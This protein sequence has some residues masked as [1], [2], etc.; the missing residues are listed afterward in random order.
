M[1]GERPP[2]PPSPTVAAILWEASNVALVRTLGPRKARAFVDALV[3]EVRD[4]ETVSELSLMRRG[5]K[6]LVSADREVVTE[7]VRTFQQAVPALIR[8]I[9]R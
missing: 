9:P 8:A 2:P 6:S 1:S 5:G 4:R 3:R 7:A